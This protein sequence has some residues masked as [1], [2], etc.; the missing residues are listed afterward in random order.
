M[1]ILQIRLVYFE[2]ALD[3]LARCTCI[4]WFHFE[5]HPNDEN[6][7][8]FLDLLNTIPDIPWRYP[9]LDKAGYPLLNSMC[10]LKQT[11][12]GSNTDKMISRQSLRTKI[13]E[14]EKVEDEGKYLTE[15]IQ[16]HPLCSFDSTMFVCR[17]RTK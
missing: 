11:P 6:K 15:A 1:G 3:I 14:Q 10:P 4:R 13:S 8:P 16:G 17:Y 5:Q 9:L 2:F 7:T 12:N